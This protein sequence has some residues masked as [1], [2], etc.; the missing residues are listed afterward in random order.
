M[1]CMTSWFS[2]PAART[3]TAP[4][5]PRAALDFHRSLP[6]YAVTPLVELPE[7]ADELGVGRVLVKDESSRLGLPAF[8]VLGAS[9]ACHQVL[10]RRP[11]ALL[12]T[13]TDG[14]H[15]RAVARMAAHFGVGATVFVPAVMSAEHRD[16]I[17]AEGAEVVRVDGDYDETVRAAADYAQGSARR[18]LVQDTAW[19][20][21]TEVPALIVEG[22]QTLVQE[23]DEQLG[24]APDLVA[25]PV[26]VGSLAEAVV[27]HYRR[28][29]AEHPSVLSVEPDTAACV[30][31][32]LAAG[33][34]V[35]VGT[36]ATVMAGLNCGTVS[37]AAWPVLRDGCDAAVC[38]SDEAAQRAVADLARLG[39]SSG[40][41]GASTLAGVRAAVSTAE[42]REAVALSDDSVVVLLSTEGD[43]R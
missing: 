26:G 13:A 37:S 38:V 23:V 16:R 14:N 40:P 9:W 27:R 32:S 34:P 21:Y 25:V 18:A 20:G 3:W 39:L 31:A 8:K 30:L 42:R 19:D 6:G 15:G 28:A 24:A 33:R 5:G 1:V 2:C 36:A 7:L 12:V 29:G 22:Y 17:A 43:L 11:G 10:Q 4:A 35:T 41:S